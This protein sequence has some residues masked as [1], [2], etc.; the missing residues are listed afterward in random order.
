MPPVLR[1]LV[2]TFHEVILA[3]VASGLLLWHSPI[4]KSLSDGLMWVRQGQSQRSSTGLDRFLHNGIT[5]EIVL[6][7]FWALVGLMVYG[8]VWAA[9]TILTEFRN[10]IVLVR[11]YTNKGDHTRH[12]LIEIGQL[13]IALV[14]LGLL[15]GLVV[16]YQSLFTVTLQQQGTTWQYVAADGLAGLEL[17]AIILLA[18]RLVRGIFWLPELEVNG[19]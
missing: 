16:I 11:D 14:V 4:L 2:P 9:Q 8:V 19:D 6:I 13:V 7:V 15:A 3:I 5:S 10:D 12:Y 17:A 18:W 1:Q